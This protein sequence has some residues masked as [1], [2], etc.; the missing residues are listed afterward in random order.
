[1]FLQQQKQF[2]IPELETLRDATSSISQNPNLPFPSFLIKAEFASGLLNTIIL[3]I[4]VTKLILP[5]VK[6]IDR[7]AKSSYTFINNS[8][9]KEVKYVED[10][11][12]NILLLTQSDRVCIGVFHNGDKW[13]SFHF[14]K[15]SIIYEAVKP[16]IQSFKKKFHSVPIEKLLDEIKTINTSEFKIFNYNSDLNIGCRQHMDTCGLTS[17]SSRLISKNSEASDSIIAVINCHKVNGTFNQSSFLS[18]DLIREFNRLCW[19]LSRINESKPL[20]DI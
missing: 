5:A 12:E 8:Y 16:G 11:L 9:F 17:I 20:P 19:A 10:I 7:L 15:M 14:M 6:T 2:G 4:T 13:G 1:M 18:E 3:I